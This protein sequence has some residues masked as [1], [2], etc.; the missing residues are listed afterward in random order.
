[1]GDLEKYG[2]LRSKKVLVTGAGGF[3]GSHLSETLMAGGYHVP[4]L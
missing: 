4:A 1:M 2:S 3:V